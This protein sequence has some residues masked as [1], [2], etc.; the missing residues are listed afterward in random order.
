M[1]ALAIDLCLTPTIPLCGTGQV[2]GGLV[3]GAAK[4]T[5]GATAN[6]MLS[7][8]ADGFTI[9]ARSV[10]DGMLSALDASTRVD[11]RADWFTAETRVIAVVTLPVV[12]LL[13][14]LQ[15][16]GSAL[17][18]E[19][20]GLARGVVGVGKALVGGAFAILALQA[21]LAACDGMCQAVLAGSGQS[22]DSLARRLAQVAVGGGNP[23]LAII[24]AVWAIVSAFL[25]WAVLIIRKALLLVTGAF[26]MVAFAGSAWDATRIWL[27]RW[28]EIAGALVFCKLVIVVVFVLGAG[29]FGVSG[30]GSS[31]GAALSDVVAGLLLLSVATLAPWLTWQFVHW[32]GAEIAGGLHQSMARGPVPAAA[33]VGAV[34]AQRVAASAA[35]GP[36]AGATLR[37]ARPGKAADPTP[38]RGMPVHR[39]GAP[40]AGRARPRSEERL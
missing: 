17:R 12:V 39:L 21:A 29:A 11:L 32:S 26:T 4:A 27:R 30:H 31:R 10:I 28:V 5:A 9:A 35:A 25:L 20:G 6:A 34:T 40:G 18:R 7:S 36:A 15:V 19:P 22:I 13:F 2:I 3:G 8:I 38:P 16:A 33:R 24:V 1:A 14:V 23:I 37:A